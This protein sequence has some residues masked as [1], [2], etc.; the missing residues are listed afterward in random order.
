MGYEATRFLG[1]ALAAIMACSGCAGVR[2]HSFEANEIRAVLDRQASAWNRG[3]MPGFLA[4][5]HRSPKITFSSAQGMIRGWETIRK[6]YH[7]RYPDQAAMGKL[8]FLDLEVVVLAD[9]VALALGRWQ[10][11]RQADR[12]GGVFSVVLFR[13]PD[14]WRIIHDHTSVLAMTEAAAEAKQ[15]SVDKE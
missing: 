6:R 2:G 4:T 12:P 9:D 15:Q 11:E 14:G 3:D 1:L 13:F 8:E 10:L 7:S 5:Y